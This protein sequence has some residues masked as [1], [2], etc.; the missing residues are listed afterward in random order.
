MAVEPS[1]M[2][3]QR[4][5]TG[6]ARGMSVYAIT[7]VVAAVMV[8]GLMIGSRAEAMLIDATA[9]IDTVLD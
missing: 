9:E 2:A 3:E 4:K 1:V 5:L 8:F 6:G 7:V